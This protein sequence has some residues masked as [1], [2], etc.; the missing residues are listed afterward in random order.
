MKETSK[1]KEQF[2]D[3][4]FFVVKRIIFGTKFSNLNSIQQSRQM[5]KYFIIEIL[6]ETIPIGP[7]R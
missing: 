2:K 5:L 1:Q 4:P 3:K 6:R 7:G